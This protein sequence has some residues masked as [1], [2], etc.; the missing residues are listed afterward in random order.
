MFRI[1]MDNDV[2]RLIPDSSSLKRPGLSSRSRLSING[3]S[4]ILLVIAHQ[5]ASLHIMVNDLSVRETLFIAAL[6]TIDFFMC[7]P[8]SCSIQHACE[9]PWADSTVTDDARMQTVYPLR[10]WTYLCWRLL[11]AANL[12]QIIPHRYAR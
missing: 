7:G 3:V 11:Q 6:M 8:T 12:L 1:L 4:Q 9:S 2:P 5:R 10:L